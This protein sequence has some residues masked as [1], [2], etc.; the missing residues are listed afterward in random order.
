LLRRVN[1]F[2]SAMKHP[3]SVDRHVGQR[4]RQLRLERG[5]DLSALSLALGITPPR[6]LQMEEGRERVSAGA[7]RRLS[8]ILRV[9]P[10]EFFSGYVLSE[11]PATP[12]GLMDEEQQLLS[13]FSRIADPNARALILAL[14]AAYAEYGG[15]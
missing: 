14:V 9:R 13:H 6:L 2:E 5:V 12:V 1:A 8:Q 4:L 7:M 3:N 15:R 11:A 10:S